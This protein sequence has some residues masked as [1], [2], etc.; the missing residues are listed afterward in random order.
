MTILLHIWTTQ[1]LAMQILRNISLIYLHFAKIPLGVF[2]VFFSLMLTGN[3][4]K[5]YLFDL[6]AFCKK[7]EPFVS[8]YKRQIKPYNNTAHNILKDKIDLILPQIQK[9]QKCG[10]ITI[11]ASSFIGLAYEHI[12]SFLH[13]R[14]NKALQKAVKAVNSYSV[15]QINTIRK[16][17]A[18]V[19]HL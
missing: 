18:Y 19:W 12:S 5:K 15:Q 13:N 8:Y 2:T 16:F 6:L 14:R 17:I 10:I 3:I 4:S 1:S 11:I 9:K 7:I